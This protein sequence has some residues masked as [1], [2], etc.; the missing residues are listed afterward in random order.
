V[1]S[2]VGRA[3]RL[4]AGRSRIGGSILDRGIRFFL[5]HKVRTYSRA[6]PASYSAIAVGSFSGIKRTSRHD[7]SLIK[8]SGIFNLDRVQADTG[9]H[10]VFY[11]LDADG[12]ILRSKGDDFLWYMPRLYNG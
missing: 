12:F 3:S 1:G 8:P 10:L 11:L 2:S 6:H 4:R 9:A 5:L 7:A